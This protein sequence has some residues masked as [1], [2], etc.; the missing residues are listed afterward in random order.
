MMFNDGLTYTNGESKTLCLVIVADVDECASSPCVNG[1]S[2][3]DALA[4][5]SCACA[6]GYD[7]LTCTNGEIRNK[8][9]K[10]IY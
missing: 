10:S 6:P 5:F 2:C 4:G 9:R 8:L 1:G 3:T 7:G